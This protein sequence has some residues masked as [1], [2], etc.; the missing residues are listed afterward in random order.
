MRRTYI[1]IEKCQFRFQYLLLES[2]LQYQNLQL[3]GAVEAFLQCIHRIAIGYSLLNLKRF[4]KISVLHIMGLSKQSF[5]SGYPLLAHPNRWLVPR[6]LFRDGL[7]CFFKRMSQ[8][9]FFR[10]KNMTPII[11]TPENRT[12]LFSEHFSIPN[13]FICTVIPLNTPPN[14]RTQITN[15]HFP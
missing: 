15:F 4:C 9:T 8:N 6:F 10:Y 1:R 5:E 13:F 12:A 3:D 7:T 2:S 14:L 11:D